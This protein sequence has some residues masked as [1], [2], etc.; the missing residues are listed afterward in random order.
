MIVYIAL[1]F[2]NGAF[3]SSSRAVNGQLSTSVGAFRASLWNHLVGFAFLSTVL[4]VLNGFQFGASPPLAAYLGGIFGALF[5]AVSSYVFPR[6]GALNAGV[7]VIAGQMIAAVVIDAIN[8]HA[9]PSLLR[10][11]GVAIVL[12][13]VW[14]SRISRSRAA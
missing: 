9:A 7:L 12:A 8:R 1:A 10:Y 4:I 13:G 14:L 3:I 5:V 6:L 11:L 2:L